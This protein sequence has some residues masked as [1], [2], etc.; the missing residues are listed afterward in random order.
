MTISKKLKIGW[1]GQGFSEV[2]AKNDEEAKNYK[3]E[4]Y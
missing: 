2:I 3:F 4:Q 1:G